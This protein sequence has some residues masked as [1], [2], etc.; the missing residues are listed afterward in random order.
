M[1]TSLIEFM[2][3]GLDL[4]QMDP[5]A[6]SPLGSPTSEMRSMRSPFGHWLSLKGT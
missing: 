3:K 4:P 1:E 5:K 6:Y 2:T